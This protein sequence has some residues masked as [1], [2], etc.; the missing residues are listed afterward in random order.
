MS[1][2]SIEEAGLLQLL[3]ALENLKE[4]ECKHQDARN[5]WC[6]GWVSANEDS[7][8]S[9]DSK[10][11][12]AKA[13]LRKLKSI[14]KVLATVSG[15]LEET[16]ER[17]TRQSTDV[18]RISG[19]ST[20]PDDVLARIF[21]INHQAYKYWG[22]TTKKSDYVYSS[23][24]LARV[25]HRFR[26]IA[27]HIPSLWE[28]ISNAHEEGWISIVKGRYRNP[29]VYI[30]YNVP[31]AQKSITRLL[32]LACPADRWKGLDICF[33]EKLH[34]SD[35]INRVSTISKG[36]LPS[37]ETLS[38][39][40][41]WDDGKI[42]TDGEED[43]THENEDEDDGNMNFSTNISESESDLLSTWNLPKLNRITLANLIPSEMN[44]PNL[45]T[46]RIDL[47]NVMGSNHWD[48]HTLN[49]FLGSLP[50]LESL[51]FTFTNAFSSTD[52]DFAEEPIKMS[53]LKSLDISVQADTEEGFV[54]SVMNMLDV[55]TLYS[56]KVSMCPISLDEPIE[57]EVKVEEWV[58]AIFFDSKSSG[59]WKYLKNPRLF[60]N[61][62]VFSFEI[63]EGVHRSSSYR[64]LFRSLPKI[65][66]LTIVH[67]GCEEPNL[68]TGDL[69][70]LR[71]LRYSKCT[72]YC[73]GESLRFLKERGRMGKI[74]KVEMEGCYNLRS[75]KGDLQEALGDKFVWKG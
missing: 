57:P 26:R 6:P 7:T 27:L 32:E 47:I 14:K 28:V 71:S 53:N 17:V 59:L 34:G 45:R 2:I 50:L 51:S 5:I 1:G 19:F 31:R 40:L 52:Y 37:L 65:R 9:I 43:G 60:P 67:P 49:E 46:C 68:P 18:L 48:L 41:E 30:A 42:E 35:A 4:S 69:T 22:D 8:L 11:Q 13:T 44:C 39:R 72:S 23:S 66:D 24:V 10:A 63:E 73:S 20:L 38:L 29:D 61:V 33:V 55:S 70:N 64:E 25:C 12:S 21:E 62:E 36:Q 54:K 3:A 15:S 56:L 16:F 58:N 74:D 75:Y